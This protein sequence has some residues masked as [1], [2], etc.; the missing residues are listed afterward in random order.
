MG[1]SIRLGKI[2]GIPI[3]IN[4]SWIFVFLLFIYLMSQQF[5]DRF[6]DLPLAQ[7]WVFALLTTVFFFLSVLAHELSHSL[8]AVRR[9]IPVVVITLFIFGGVSLLAHAARRPF[10]ELFVASVGSR[11]RILL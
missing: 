7:R 2:L 6:P 10:D 3:D 9:G 5:A 11:T 1:T 4:Y 8:V